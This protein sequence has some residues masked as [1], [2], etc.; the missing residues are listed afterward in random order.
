MVWAKW[1]EERRGEKGREKKR[2]RGGTPPRLE[3][4]EAPVE[5]RREKFRAPGLPDGHKCI[6]FVDI[7]WPQFSHVT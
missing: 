4:K 3:F 1:M 6:H 2:G 5:A 7:V